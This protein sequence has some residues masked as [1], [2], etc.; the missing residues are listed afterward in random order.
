MIQLAAV[1]SLKAN[2]SGHR[3]DI[4]LIEAAKAIAA[5]YN[6]MFIM[7]KD[8]EEAAEFVLPHRM[9]KPDTERNNT[10][11]T[12]QN[13]EQEQEKEDRPENNEQQAPKNE[14]LRPAQ[15]NDTQDE[16]NDDSEP[17]DNT[18]NAPAPREDQVDQADLSVVLPPMWIQPQR[19]RLK[20]SGD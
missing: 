19:L 20:K 17:E 3:A 9:R 10:P 8:I 5:L 14:D 16:S 11:Q 6:R 4:Y 15:L 1:Y 13:K 18:E 12:E 7:P 2:V